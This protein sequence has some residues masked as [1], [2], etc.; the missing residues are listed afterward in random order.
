[1]IRRGY[2]DSRWGQ[3]HFRETGS[4]PRPALVCLHATAYS[5]R[6]FTPLMPVVAGERRVIA[7][8]TPGYGESDGP[9]SPIAFERYADVIAEAVAPL[10]DG[11]AADL[12]GYHTGALI[13]TEWAAARPASVRRLVL[14]GIPFF[15]GDE[16]EPWRAKLVHR[17]TLDAT[18]DQFAARWDYFVTN[19]TAGLSLE[20]AYE[21]FVD[22]L[23]VFPDDWW[24]HASLFDYDARSRLATVTQPVLVLNPATA[25]AEPSRRAAL[26]MPDATVVEMPALGG[27]IFDLATDALAERI[28]AFLQRE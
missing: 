11:Q 8:D 28:D 19:R 20:R 15:E 1:M 9:P 6:T 2:V 13:A 17:H 27:A 18:F 25:L 3:L 22:E 23:K 7:I 10:L 26:A 21:C 5:S 14:I 16:R 12:L 4:G 24:A